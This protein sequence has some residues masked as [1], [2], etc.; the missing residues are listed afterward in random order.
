ME[1][2][3]CGWF[4]K[5]VAVLGLLVGHNDLTRDLA[6]SLADAPL[7]A[8]ERD[9][10]YSL[11]EAKKS[12]HESFEDSQ[13][14]EERRAIL[15]VDVGW[16]ALAAGKGQGEKKDSARL[17]LVRGPRLLCG[18]AH[19]NCPLWIFWVDRRGE[20][21]LVFDGG[22]YELTTR[23]TVSHGFR[24]IETSWSMPGLITTEAYQWDGRRYREIDCY[25]TRMGGSGE[26]PQ[27]TREKTCNSQ[28]YP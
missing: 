9:Q 4:L 6:Y 27:I 23:E 2:V 18:A 12:V 28:P 20:V 17:I 25:E 15:G 7:T 11:I 19:G 24:D 22:G 1:I 8:H 26:P 10:I 21:R 5:F 14:D 3:H 13:R 16:I